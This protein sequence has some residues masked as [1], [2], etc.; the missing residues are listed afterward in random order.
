MSGLGE[1]CCSGAFP[2]LIMMFPLRGSLRIEGQIRK[3]NA[4][5]EW[6]RTESTHKQLPAR[7]CLLLAVRHGRLVLHLGCFSGSISVK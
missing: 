1:T 6:H 7:L 4:G 3:N 2:K 5:N